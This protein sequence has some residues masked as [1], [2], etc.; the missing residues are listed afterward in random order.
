MND[1]LIFANSPHGIFIISIISVMLYLFFK[2]L[3]SHSTVHKDFK[4]VLVSVGVLGTFIG[5]V[6]GLWE[7]DTSDISTSVPKLLDGL[8]TAFLTSI[9]GMGLAILLSI[10]QKHKKGT[11]GE[12]EI[13][14][15][16]EI[17]RKLDALNNVNEQLSSINKGI[18]VL[19]LVNTKLDAIDSRIKNEFAQHRGDVFT[20]LQEQLQIINENLNKSIDNLSKRTTEEINN[21]IKVLSSMDSKLD[22]LPNIEKHLV[23]MG[24]SLEIL[25]LVNTKLDSIDTRIKDEFINNRENLFKF[26]QEQLQT[27][28]N[29]LNTAVETLSKGATE[30]I[31]KALQDVIK[32]FNNNLT[33]QFGDNFKQLNESVL[34]MIKWQENY[35][36]SVQ[37]FEIKLTETLNNVADFNQKNIKNMEAWGEEISAQ[38]QTITQIVET[39]TNNLLNS[40]SEKLAEIN[41]TN[42]ENV[43]KLTETIETNSTKLL[44][45]FDENLSNLS[46]TNSQNA[47][48]LTEK[49]QE[50]ASNILTTFDE[51]LTQIKS[52]TNEVIES[53]KTL[54]GELV[55]QIKESSTAINETN[56]NIKGMVESYSEINSTSEQLKNII[57]TNQ[58]QIENLE[59]GLTG[60]TKIGEEV[61]EINEILS[62]FVVT[63]QNTLSQQSESITKLVQDIAEQLPESME[64]LNESL[65]SLTNKFR[66]DYEHFLQRISDIEK[67]ERLK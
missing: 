25:S 52:N 22:L 60:L 51:H 3:L 9:I 43:S 5:I 24:K 36:T 39:N 19:P 61:K 62:N 20:F 67:G 26:L 10:I 63:L 65:T 66:D 58:R 59:S 55:E 32:D 44:T 50:V 15:L 29:S 30:E 8:K 31:I 54:S 6:I 21:G 35:K 7:F 12:D 42:A 38:M 1:I 17:S 57:E 4:S 16:Q 64:S 14:T 34:N 33:E 46:E 45:Q 40:F 53:V 18:E 49:V 13:A 56:T 41:N 47:N 28:N 11:S 48:A 23:G 2:D 27:I 37:E